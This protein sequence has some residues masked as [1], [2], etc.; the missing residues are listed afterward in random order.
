MMNIESDVP[1]ANHHCWNMTRF[2]SQIDFIV[3][4]LFSTVRFFSMLDPVYIQ[5]VR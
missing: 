2:L 5:F 3:D 4:F 1:H